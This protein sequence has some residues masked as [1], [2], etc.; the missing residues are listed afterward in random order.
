MDLNFRPKA[1]GARPQALSPTAAHTLHH[2]QLV[3]F[4]ELVMLGD[5]LIGL[6]QLALE[7][8]GTDAGNRGSFSCLDGEVADRG[9]E[10]EFIQRDTDETGRA[11]LLG[12]E[13]VPEALLR[14]SQ[15]FRPIPSGIHS[16]AERRSAFKRATSSEISAMGFV[17]IRCSSACRS[18]ALLGELR[19]VRGAA[20]WS[21]SRHV[22]LPKPLVVSLE[23]LHRVA[24]DGT[25][26]GDVDC[27]LRHRQPLGRNLWISARV[28]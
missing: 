24:A 11:D 25:R 12:W 15:V 8:L 7:N 14:E 21:P 9:E 13:Q 3:G 28:R 18:P 5:R 23:L 27:G 20:G 4:R 22:G 16:C 2:A 1:V 19:C 6:L 26:I 10:R 17:G